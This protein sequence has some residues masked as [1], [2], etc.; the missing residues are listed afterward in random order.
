MAGGEIKAR[1]ALEGEREFVSAMSAAAR[2]VKALAAEERMIEAQ[3]QASGNAQQ[4]AAD[5][6]NNLRAQIA[7]QQGAVDAAKKAI[8]QLTQQG[9]QANDAAMQKWRGKL[10]DASTTLYGL[11]SRMDK[12][13]AKMTDMGN[14]GATPAATAVGSIKDKATAAKD[15]LTTLDGKLTT[16]EQ[17]LSDLASDGQGAA[18]AVG[19]IQTQAGNAKTGLSGLDGTLGTSEDNLSDLASKG[20]DQAAEALGDLYNESGDAKSGL[21]NLDGQLSTS[22]NNLSALAS[23]GA[24]EASDS[25]GD[26]RTE[27]NSAK[28]GLNSLDNK[29]KISEGKLSTL[30][31]K[32]ADPAA[33]GLEGVQE[34]ASGAA[35]NLGNLDGA[36]GKAESGMESAGG[37]AEGYGEQLQKIGKKID[38]QAAIQSIDRITGAIENTV[39]AAARATKAVI[40]IA[41]DAGEWASELKQAATEMQLDPETYQSWEYAASQMDTS[42]DDIAHG[43]QEV[44]KG[45]EHVGKKATAGNNEWSLAVAQMGINV[46][47]AGGKL[48][49][50]KELFWECID[51]LHGIGDE[52]ERA[53]KASQIFGN[54]WRK[55]NPIIEQGSEAFKALAQEGVDI[56]AIVSG[57]NVEALGDMSDAFGALGLQLNAMKMNVLA[58]LAPTFERIAQAMGT[59]VTALNEFIASEEGQQALTEL[60]NALEGIIQSFIGVDEE[61]NNGFNRLIET[62]KNGLDTFKQGLEWVQNNSQTVADAIKGIGLAYAGLKVSSTVLTFMNLLKSTPLSKISALFGGGASSAGS[63]ASAGSAGSALGGS[64]GANAAT[65]LVGGGVNAG[66]FSAV[67][68]PLALVGGVY[69][70]VNAVQQADVANQEA[71]AAELAD[72]TEAAA[73]GMGEQAA[74]WQAAM[75]TALIGYQ[76]GVDFLG[77]KNLGSPADVSRALE[78]LKTFDWLEKLIGSDQWDKLQK[79]NTSESTLDMVEETELL[80]SITDQIITAMEQTSGAATEA[81]D[82]TEGAMADGLNAAQGLAEGILAGTP[83]AVAAAYNMAALVQDAIEGALDIQSPSKVMARLGGF[84]AQG[85]AKGIEASSRDVVRA[86]DGMAGIA[87]GMPVGFGGFGRAGFPGMGPGGNS[88]SSSFY[89]DKYIQNTPEDARSLALRVQDATGWTQQGFGHRG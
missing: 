14:N 2:E 5:K 32:G 9:V 54:D 55:M 63:A 10:A 59:A 16:S 75:E 35:G 76:T 49:T 56:G 38:V 24:D 13:K 18:D 68:L 77:Q 40:D 7:A 48:K 78:G 52:G 47:D 57:E 84:T 8:Q 72:R 39:K 61:G 28:S 31:S 58:A 17:N 19:S 79:I 88:Y 50:S 23:E 73:E 67:M 69:A 42:I 21:S 86:V 6:A 15:G 65:T 45:L 43:I 71:R 83:E 70:G 41:V 80:Q 22:E 37:T 66:M 29:L 36:V 87:A 53:A 60:G 26:I 34:G 25:I 30:A 81:L 51:Y 85:F 89:V 1:I 3:F 44:E 20:A 33:D 46:R 12:A 74:Q 82:F 27:A 62:A 11:Q 4:Y 64:V